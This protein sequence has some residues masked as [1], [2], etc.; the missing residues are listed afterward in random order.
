M[1]ILENFTKL[2]FIV[3]YSYINHCVLTYAQPFSCILYSIINYNYWNESE[4]YLNKSYS[5]SGSIRDKNSNKIRKFSEG[6]FPNN[7]R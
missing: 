3:N 1:R 2:N 4:I 6:V 5:S 7:T